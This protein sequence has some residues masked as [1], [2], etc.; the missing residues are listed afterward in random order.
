VVQT[1]FPFPFSLFPFR[2][3]F[4]PNITSQQ[5][6]LYSNLHVTFGVFGRF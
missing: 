5:R 3:Q 4:R 1:V 2:R 6:G